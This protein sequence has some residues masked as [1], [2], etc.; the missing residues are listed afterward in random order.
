MID[1]LLQVGWETWSIFKEASLFLLFGFAVAGVLAV[2]VPSRVFMRFL[3]TGRVKSVLWASI[4]GGF[5]SKP[6]L[7]RSLNSLLSVYST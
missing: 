1:F 2:L 5:T 3:G 4:I 6:L 7:W